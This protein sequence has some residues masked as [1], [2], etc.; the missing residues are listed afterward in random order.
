MGARAVTR[1]C[2]KCK[3]H[4][5]I[6]HFPLPRTPGAI[7][8]CLP[9]NGQAV[10]TESTARAKHER[11]KA[12]V[13]VKVKQANPPSWKTERELRIRRMVAERKSR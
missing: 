13:R 10:P 3:R 12:R 7:Y 2:R 1:R 8:V 6:G 11:N 5:P 4:K 9:C